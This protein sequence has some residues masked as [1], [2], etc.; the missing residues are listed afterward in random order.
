MMDI[1]SN[2]GLLEISSV[3]SYSPFTKTRKLLNVYKQIYA[4]PKRNIYGFKFCTVYYF[5]RS[6]FSPER[7]MLTGGSKTSL[8]KMIAY[9]KININECNLTE[10]ESFTSKLY[11][12][13]FIYEDELNFVCGGI[14][15]KNNLSEIIISKK[16]I[17]GFNT[18]FKDHI[19]FLTAKLNETYINYDFS[20]LSYNKTKSKNSVKCEQ[21][22]LFSKRLHIATIAEILN[23]QKL[24]TNQI[25]N[26]LDF[27][28]SDSD[29]NNFLIK[30][31]NEEFFYDG[32]TKF[33]WIQLI[34]KCKSPDI[35]FY[36]GTGLFNKNNRLDLSFTV[37]TKF[38]YQ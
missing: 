22:L 2:M 35:I 25:I 20:N 31:K 36:Y 12:N 29:F 16:G 4:F 38:V 13:Y 17:I 33:T 28:F 32:K 27:I 14:N 24:V 8:N 7:I 37:F 11:D 18:I 6:K 34:R 21:S 3:I 15:K 1:L 10:E 30:N 19:N 23:H 5:K 26:A 9:L